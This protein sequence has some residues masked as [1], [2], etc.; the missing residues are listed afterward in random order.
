MAEEIVCIGDTKTFRLIATID[1]D[2]DTDWTG[3]TGTLKLWDSDNNLMGEFTS[4]I[5]DNNFEYTNGESLI[6]K[7]GWWKGKW[8]VSLGTFKLSTKEFSFYVNK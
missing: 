1:S 2:E 4:T 8:F 7:T 6:N 5:V 3:Y